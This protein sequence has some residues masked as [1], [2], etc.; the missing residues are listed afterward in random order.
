MNS[1]FWLN[2]A[3]KAEETFCHP[4][5]LYPWDD[6][7]TGVSV[8]KSD[9]SS[10]QMLAVANNTWRAHH[11]IDKSKPG[12][13][14]IFKEYFVRNKS[15]ILSGLNTVNDKDS[16]NKLSNQ[17]QQSLRPYLTNLKM[18]VYDSY[19]SIRKPIDLYF[20]HL[21]AMGRE[22]P[23]EIRPRLISILFL[24]LDSQIMGVFQLNGDHD[25]S[26]ISYNQLKS[27]G[28]NRF[29]SYGHVKTETMYLGLQ[30]EVAN[31][32]QKI[33]GLCGRPFHPIYFD[34]LWGKR[35]TRNGGNLFELNP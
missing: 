16:L 14:D 19:N 35:Y 29:S 20:Q 18:N 15:K 8:C 5:K 34:M 1:S 11:R 28:L 4:K 2:V 13:S 32:A 24:P 22:I 21:I 17:L 25:F 3:T 30:G 31:R 33:T 7:I 6:I 26:I 10:K 23:Q 12:S 27:Y 9:G